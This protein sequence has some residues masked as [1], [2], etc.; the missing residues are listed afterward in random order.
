M[1]PLHFL[2]FL[3]SLLAA[4]PTAHA[5]AT[6][7]WL[8]Q[9]HAL[10]SPTTEKKPQAIILRQETHYDYRPDG[11]CL[12]TTRVALR[13]LNAKGKSHARA[14]AY[15][16][17][18]TDKVR[19]AQAWILSG[20]NKPITYA[21]KDFTEVAPDERTSL[22]TDARILL[23]NAEANTKPGDTFAYEVSI[24]TR[25]IFSE[26]VTDL[27]NSLPIAQHLVRLTLPPKWTS[28]ATFHHH[29]AITPTVDKNKT[30]YTLPAMPAAPDEPGQPSLRRH[31][32]RLILVVTPPPDAQTKEKLLPPFKTWADLSVHFSSLEDKVC[33]VDATITAKANQLTT[34][35]TTP[36]EIIRAL[37]AHAQ[38][39]NYAMV[40]AN[41]GRGGGWIPQPAP[42]TLA[43]HYG[44]CKDKANLLRAL[45]R[46]KGINAYPIS[47]YSDSDSS[48]PVDPDWPSPYQFNH[49]IIAI[50][51]P[52]EIT[53]PAVLQ[54]PKLG[55]LLIFDATSPHAP[56]GHLPPYLYGCHALLQA[57]PDGGLITTPS[58]PT[59]GYSITRTL[60]AEL[61]PQGH[62]IA[63]AREETSGPNAYYRRSLARN[64]S[65]EEF[66]NTFTRSLNRT[67][68]GAKIQNLTPDDQF[69]DH[70]FN[71]DFEFAAPSYAQ[72]LR[73]KLLI[74]KP[75]LLARTNAPK[76]TTSKRTQ[77]LDLASSEETETLTLAFPAAFTVD[78][79]PKPVRIETP[80]A[81][82]ESTCTV[83]NQ[84][85]TYRRTYRIHAV[86]I[87]ATDYEKFKTFETQVHQAEQATAVL[88]R[89]ERF[90]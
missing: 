78:E 79:L 28:A 36:L 35:A 24:E 6:P 40:A 19:S 59:P 33:V 74:F 43:R 48:D 54:H 49:A 17:A 10:A 51:V 4:A 60:N 46:A 25:T 20:Q 66:K 52:P 23:L 58:M 53:G 12:E 29:A 41:L 64:L 84:T 75:T 1:R 34:T 2:T 70:R 83:E 22:I 87:P 82:Y 47:I 32:P 77:P 15:F 86:R 30:T 62:L 37:A 63:V 50:C 67:I 31:A 61:T 71:V 16:R 38:S 11:T 65:P 73:D 44:D 90:K 57:G 21:K 13:I 80:F 45:L 88:Q 56:V 69:Q 76:S 85:L 39:V 55:P 18:G 14:Q 8:K 68:P 5:Q 89:L 7:D 42:L 9:T 72:S 26:L 81:L 27:Q 3:L